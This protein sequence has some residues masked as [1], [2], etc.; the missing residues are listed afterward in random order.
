VAREY[1][2]WGPQLSD[3][4]IRKSGTTIIVTR[5]REPMTNPVI[6]CPTGTQFPNQRGPQT[7]II[8][9]YAGP[10]RSRGAMRATTPRSQPAGPPHEVDW[11]QVAVF[12]AGLA[13]GI[14]LGAGVALLAAPQ[15]G[16]QT[17]ADIV[18]RAR[19]VRT[20]VGR[21]GNDAWLDLQDELRGMARALRRRNAQRS[22]EQELARESALD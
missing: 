17:R 10:V 5:N 13:L 3:G 20:A 7:Q 16:T 11:M 15:S 14:T 8:M 1:I 22:A 19:R 9:S 18:R 21:R 6:R 4:Q 12:G 2:D